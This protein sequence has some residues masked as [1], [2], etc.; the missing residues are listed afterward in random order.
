MKKIILLI[1]S[2]SLI[3]S[4]TTSKEDKAKTLIEQQLKTTMKDWSSYEFVEMTKLDS[5][6]THY[7]IT[8]EYE[9]L[10]KEKSDLEMKQLEYSAKSMYDSIPDIESRLSAIKEQMEEGKKNF[11]REF[12]GWYTDYTFRGNN[13]LGAKIISK[14]RY[15]F[16]KDVTTI[17]GTIDLD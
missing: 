10:N 5:T 3:I 7:G 8:E 14:K 17:L 12:D 4:C 2:L 1:F 9:K 6:K 16:D 15:R 11:K 13:S